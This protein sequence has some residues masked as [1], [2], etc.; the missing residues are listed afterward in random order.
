MA[1]QLTENSASICND[2]RDR[3]TREL[4]SGL[5]RVRAHGPSFTPVPCFPREFFAAKAGEGL[6]TNWD[7]QRSYARPQSRDTETNVVLP[8]ASPRPTHVVVKTVPEDTILP[9][10][11]SATSTHITGP[12]T[13]NGHWRS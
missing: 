6:Y 1:R 7:P 3:G 2:A 9:Q 4:G 11:I 5:Y 8:S 12:R 13:A 10:P